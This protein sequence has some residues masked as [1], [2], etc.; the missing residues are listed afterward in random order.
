LVYRH[1]TGP[2][3]PAA[4][5]AKPAPTASNGAGR[6]LVVED[7]S[8]IALELCDTL[9]ALG[10]VVVGPANSVAEAIGL[11]EVNSPVDVAVLDVNLGGVPV[12]PL[13]ERLQAQGVPFVFCTGYEQLGGGAGDDRYRDYPVVRKPVNV[14][15]LTDEMRRLWQGAA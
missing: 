1:E 2:G 5:E 6:V 9:T 14:P 11:L 7:E 8:L 4:A 13:A 15:Q 10:W 3:H 12:Y